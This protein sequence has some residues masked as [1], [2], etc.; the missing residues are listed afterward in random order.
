MSTS[1]SAAF[2]REDRSAIENLVK[3]LDQF[4]QKLELYQVLN[5][6]QSDPH[7]K[8]FL[9]LPIWF[10]N[11]TIQKDVNNYAVFVSGIP[12]WLFYAF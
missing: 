8:I 6:A 9:L 10:Q 1:D 5:L 3:G 4:I 11:D 7:G 2:S 12:V